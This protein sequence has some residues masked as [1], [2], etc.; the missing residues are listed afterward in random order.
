MMPNYN[1]E[2]KFPFPD[3]SGFFTLYRRKK[4]MQKQVLLRHK[5]VWLEL[6]EM[7]IISFSNHL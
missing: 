5:E 4:S 1:L 6:T 7:K 3:I 2:Y